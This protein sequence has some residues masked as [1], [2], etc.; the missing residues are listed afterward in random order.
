M[1]KR[2]LFLLLGMIILFF[3]SSIT[4]VKAAGEPTKPETSEAYANAPNG[5]KLEKFVDIPSEYTYQQNNR[6][7]S[8]TSSGSL[9][10]NYS[11]NIIQLITTEKLR[12]NKSALL[13]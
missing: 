8:F 2:R 7:Y 9:L 6:D 10:T 11:T 5:M 1:R 3:V 13:G 4:P 12:L